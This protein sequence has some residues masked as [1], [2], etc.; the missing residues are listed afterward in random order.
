MKGTYTY[1]VYVP[2]ILHLKLVLVGLTIYM[3][4][5]VETTHTMHIYRI[6]M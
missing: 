4:H 2:F 6:T 5:I 1:H 3:M